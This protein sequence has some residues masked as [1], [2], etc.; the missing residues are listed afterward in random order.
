MARVP[1]FGRIEPVYL[2][3]S[4]GT[5]GVSLLLN[6]QNVMVMFFLVTVLKIEPA[7][8]GLLVTGSKL[9]DTFTDPVMGTITDRTK[10]RWGRRRPYL[11]LGGIGCALSFI[12][13]F[14]VPELSDTATLAYVLAALLLIATFYT[15]FNVPY[16]AMPAEM[17]DGYHERSVMM[18]Y[19]VFFIAGATYIATSGTPFLVSVLTNDYGLSQRAA[20]GWMGVAIGS[21]IGLAMVAA[22]FG[23]AKARFTE[24]TKVNISLKEKLALI[25]SNTPFVL[26]M[27]I[28][29]SGL[30]ALASILA[31]KFF[32]VVYIMQQD[33]A[34]AAIF[35]TTSLI[36]QLVALPIWLKIS[37][38]FGKKFILIWSGV[39]Q[40]LFTATW[41]WSGPDETSFIYGLRGLLLG[42]GGAGTLLGTQAILPDV[43]EYDYRRTGLR[44][45]GIY[46]GI[47]S[48]IEKLAFS[49]SAVVIGGFLS[50]MNF[51]RNAEPGAQPESALF[52]IMACQALLPI[53]MYS[54]KLVLLYFFKLDEQTLKSAEQVTPRT[55]EG[56]DRGKEAS[57]TP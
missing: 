7:L 51:D 41:F 3:W 16:L 45:E 43:M 9:Y 39:L 6:T 32:F 15:V 57:A 5:V 10:S 55:G 48:F 44:R 1:F 37:K 54:I 19:R 17:T 56:I 11:F 47:A 40:I 27:G 18:S 52:A 22:F 38:R 24:A 4:V 50:Y 25:A 49:L 8:A 46:A 14:A 33:L 31:S 29:L 26:F 30:F 36:G 35:G 13:L 53:A 42:I 2:G 12:M 34:W 21:L 28:K 20:Y 23:T